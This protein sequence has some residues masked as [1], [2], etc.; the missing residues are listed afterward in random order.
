[1]INREDMLELSRRMTPARSS[2]SRA[3]GAY[4]DEEGYVDGTFNIHFSKLSAGERSKN[5]K[6]AKT[7][8]LSKTNENLT[9][10]TISRNARKLGSLWQLLDGI[11]E[12]ELKNDAFLDILYEL[13]GEN[14]PEGEPLACTIYFGQYD[15]P[16]K[17]TD[18]EWLEG[19]EEVYTYLL[20]TVSPQE[21]QYEA[22]IPEFGFLYPVFKQRTEDRNYINI[23]EAEHERYKCLSS[24]I[25]EAAK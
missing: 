17:G 8:L 13:V 23:F 5:L 6:M 12:S 20:C 19:S 16:V 3:A 18:K 10:H 25:R 11:L 14:L 1:M 2:I 24:W 21:E 4:Y 9:E 22:G 7:I 15:V